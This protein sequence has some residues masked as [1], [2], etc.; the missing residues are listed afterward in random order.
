MVQDLGALPSVPLLAALDHDRLRWLAARST[1]RA[2]DAGCLVA[3]RG[4]PCTHLIVVEAGA[5]TSVHDTIDG[6]GGAWASSRRRV[7][8]TRSRCSTAGDTR[9]HGWRLPDRGCG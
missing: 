3:I 5:L 7:R 8:S 4:Q 1:V 9:Q 2:V 6:S